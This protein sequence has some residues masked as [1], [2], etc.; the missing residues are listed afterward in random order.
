MATDVLYLKM[1]LDLSPL[2]TKLQIYSV[3]CLAIE[4]ISVRSPSFTSSWLSTNYP[5]LVIL[6]QSV[7][8][9]WLIWLL[10]YS[11]AP[12]YKVMLRMCKVFDGVGAI[13]SSGFALD[14]QVLNNE[15]F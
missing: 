5:L 6:V 10:L 12:R 8:I 2:I 11:R 3:E 1:D 15:T 9:W 4:Q 14:S 13:K 7:Y